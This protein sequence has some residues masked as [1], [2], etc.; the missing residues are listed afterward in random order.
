MAALGNVRQTAERG[1]HFTPLDM[2]F[3]M[4]TGLAILE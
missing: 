1:D 4:R 2:Q 3:A